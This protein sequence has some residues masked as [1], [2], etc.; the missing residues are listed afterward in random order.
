MSKRFYWLR[1]KEGFFNDLAMKKLRRI[2]GGDTYTII[3]LKMMLL[4]VR[5]KGVIY[6]EG[7][8]NSF[9]EELALALDED[10]DNVRI[11]LSFLNKVG[12]I[13]QETSNKYFLP[14]VPPLIGSETDKAEYM[15]NRRK[16]EALEAL[17]DSNCLEQKS[18]KLE[19]CGNNV[20]QNSNNV[21]EVFQHVTDVLP[22]RNQTVPNRKLDIDIDID[23]EIEKRESI[24]REKTMLPSRD[25]L[26]P[27]DKIKKASEDASVD[28]AIQWILDRLNE[29]LPGGKRFDADDETRALI[30]KRLGE[31]YI[32]TDFQ[33]VI[34]KKTKE[35][36]GS[37][38]QNNLKPR[39][40]FGLHFKEYLNELEVPDR[41][42]QPKN[43]FNDM[44]HSE[45]D[46][47]RIEQENIAAQKQAY[48]G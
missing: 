37:K 24:E 39:V 15:R 18:N 8:E 28:M 26:A 31:G 19:Q 35:W 21:T 33:T 45:Y 44:I 40:L 4:S 16:I 9:E 47:N 3:Y 20:T 23:K 43:Q 13:S 6:F 7:I 22:E 48:G 38:A 11:A 17:S 41:N 10:V 30:K 14:E 12:F 36:L 32:L 1:L 5:N 34:N 29:K 46:F 2:A 25:R 27:S 42:A